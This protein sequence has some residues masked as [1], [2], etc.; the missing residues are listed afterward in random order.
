MDAATIV[1]LAG[2]VLAFALFT[3]GL[4]WADLQTRH[5]GR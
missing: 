2:V 4:M 3:G 5:V 1:I